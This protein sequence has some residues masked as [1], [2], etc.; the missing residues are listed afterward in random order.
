MFRTVSEIELFHCT[1]VVQDA[2]R[3]PTRHVFTRIAKCTDVDGGI[4]INVL[5]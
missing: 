2:L 5:Y 4:F 3:A 1:A